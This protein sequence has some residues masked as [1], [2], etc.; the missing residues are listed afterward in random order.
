MSASNK[1]RIYDYPD[2]YE[3]PFSFRDIPHEVNVFEQCIKLFSR[4]PVHRVLELA[5]GPAPHMAELISRGYEYIGID[6]NE[7]MLD[8]ARTKASR[9]GISPT[10]LNKNI[11]RF[12]LEQPVDFAFIL[13][14]SLYVADD[15]ELSDH[16]NS[17]ATA[18][19]PGGLY[20]LDWC[21]QFDRSLEASDSW[22]NEKDGLRIETSFSLRPIDPAGKTFEEIITMK[23]EGSGEGLELEERHIKR[24]IYS[25]EF[26]SAI[27]K[28]GRFE[29]VGN[30]NNWNLDEPIT[31][32]M[33]Q[34]D[35]SKIVRPI[36]VIRRA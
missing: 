36:T 20:L 19:S 33:M 27:E 25:E 35:N 23:V 13:L 32:E 3:V 11:V 1:G 31:A 30:W 26:L 14:G 28:A 18:L 12:T 6:L 29:F 8:Y 10:L 2:Y 24:A 5:C 9:A 16:L 15:N 17:V 34:S 4:I 21:L 22:V 7:R